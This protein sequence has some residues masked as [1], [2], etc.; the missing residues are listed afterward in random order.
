MK[1]DKGVIKRDKAGLPD[2]DKSKLR[3]W[4]ENL[5]QAKPTLEYP[6]FSPPRQINGFVST[7]PDDWGSQADFD[8]DLR[9]YA[10]LW[11]IASLEKALDKEEGDGR[12]R[13]CF[14]VL[15]TFG[16][17]GPNLAQ[18]RRLIRTRVF[19]ADSGHSL[20]VGRFE[21]LT[22]RCHAEICELRGG[23]SQLGGTFRYLAYREEDLAHRRDHFLSNGD[24]VAVI[25][26]DL[27][28]RELD[29][30]GTSVLGETRR[31]L[32]GFYHLDV[33]NPARFARWK[34]MARAILDLRL[35]G[36]GPTQVRDRLRSDLDLNPTMVQWLVECTQ[37][38]LPDL[39]WFLDDDTFEVVNHK[40]RLD[41]ADLATILLD[42]PTGLAAFRNL[43]WSGEQAEG[44]FRT[45]RARSRNPHLWGLID[46]GHGSPQLFSELFSRH[47][48]SPIGRTR[49]GV[50]LSKA[51]MA[52]HVDFADDV[53]KAAL[54]GVVAARFDLLA[55]AGEEFVVRV[56]TRE[57]NGESLKRFAAVAEEAARPLFSRPEFA[58]RCRVETCV[59]W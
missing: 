34:M 2:R 30:T 18:Y 59:A 28:E 26:C 45:L 25:A 51:Q 52:E 56:P 27:L 53:M 17:T 38:I 39:G 23:Q 48:L 8:P 46:Q 35:R 36:L 12:V 47:T 21:N 37:D 50:F 57:S 9:A 58:P 4:I 16:S 11:A 43:I 15:P 5:A 33:A 41:P 1:W 10:E 40:L 44:V 14:R 31:S 22:L 42:K 32:E 7:N 19:G 3:S 6:A 49:R 29:M 55:F 24:P 20:V 13:A 54:F